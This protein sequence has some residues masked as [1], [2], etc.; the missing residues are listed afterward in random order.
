MS[1]TSLICTTKISDRCGNANGKVLVKC[2]G[3]N[4][5]PTARP[6]GH[7][8]LG[9]P[10]AA[11]GRT[12]HT[13]M[14]CHLIPGQALMTQ[15]QDQLGGCGIW[16]EPPLIITAGP[17][18][19]ATTPSGPHAIAKHHPSPGSLHKRHGHDSSKP[20]ICFAK[21]DS[22]TRVPSSGSEDFSTFTDVISGCFVFVSGGDANDG[23]PTHEPPPGVQY[24]GE[25]AGPRDPDGGPDCA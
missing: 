6:L 7:W 3:E 23:P 12:R 17:P 11:P 4:L 5:L 16:G 13:D 18:S 9:P 2:V 14:L 19:W 20:S 21:A 24:R 1:T 15:L 10:V 25:F 22:Q 8:R